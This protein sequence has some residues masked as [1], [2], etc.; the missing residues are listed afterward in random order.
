M[1]ASPQTLIVCTHWVH[2]KQARGKRRGF[3]PR[4]TP[5]SQSQYG[6]F[7]SSQSSYRTLSN[8]QVGR[9]HFAMTGYF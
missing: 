7:F 2:H 8:Q 5:V 1:Y 6:F 9:F 4:S 3:I